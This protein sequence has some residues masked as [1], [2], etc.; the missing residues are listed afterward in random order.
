VTVCQKIT[1]RGV[2]IFAH[3]NHHY[4]GHAP[5]TVRLFDEVWNEQ[6]GAEDQAQTV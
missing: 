3:A 6:A 5:G 2:P 1:T 4:A